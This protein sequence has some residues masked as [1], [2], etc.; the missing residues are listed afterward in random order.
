MADISD[1]LLDLGFTKGDV[2][3]WQKLSD[4]MHLSDEYPHKVLH[5]FTRDDVAVMIEQNMSP[6]SSGGV[7]VVM[8]HPPVMV[9]ES[10]KGRVAIPN[11]ETNHALIA[12]VV[13][14]LS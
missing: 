7:E 13:D 11:F 2:E 1:V 6:D 14:D 3:P 8:K 5:F 10:P 9:V 4:A 12:S